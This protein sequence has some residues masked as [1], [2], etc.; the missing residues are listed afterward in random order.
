MYFGYFGSLWLLFPV[1]TCL[2]LYLVVWVY[3]FLP[4][5]LRFSFI[6]LVALFL[7]VLSCVSDFFCGLLVYLVCCY[8]CHVGLVFP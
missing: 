4:L 6:C 1:L 5:G 7:F 3:L 8:V 2:N